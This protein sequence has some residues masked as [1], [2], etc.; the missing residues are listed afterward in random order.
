MDIA[1]SAS[2]LGPLLHLGLWPTQPGPP[3]F[4]RARLRQPSTGKSGEQCPGMAGVAQIP[5]KYFLPNVNTR[6][7]SYRCTTH[8]APTAT[9]TGEHRSMT[10]QDGAEPGLHGSSTSNATGSLKPER[11]SS[12]R[13]LWSRICCFISRKTA[14]GREMG[15]GTGIDLPAARWPAAK[16]PDT[17]YP[18][19]FPDFSPGGG[20]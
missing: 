17:I 14:R 5:P 3:K 15:R 8:S 19:R 9:K 16:W 12:T 1:H 7:G 10:E 4:T 13:T 6:G 18:L 2:P 20:V 11:Q